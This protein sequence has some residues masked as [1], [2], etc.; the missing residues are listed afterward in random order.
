MD[1]KRA[2]LHE[3]GV[4]PDYLQTKREEVQI[5]PPCTAKREEP[6]KRA[7]EKRR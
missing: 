7:M 3:G 2:G 5:A 6:A 4:R 1:E